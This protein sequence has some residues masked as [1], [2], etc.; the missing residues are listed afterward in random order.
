MI[1]PRHLWLR[2]LDLIALLAVVA[3]IAFFAT[4]GA[5]YLLTGA[6]R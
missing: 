6:I 3:I 2:R 1:R 5:R 4:V